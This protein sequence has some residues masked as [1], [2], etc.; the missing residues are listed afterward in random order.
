MRIDGSCHCGAIAYTAEVDPETVEIC[1]CTDCQALS[2]SAFRTVVPV[3]EDDFTLTAGEP[4]VYIKT[5]DSGAQRVQTFCSNCG[6]PIYSTSVGEGPKVFGIRV[7]TARQRDDLVP[8]SQF[9]A[10]S[11]QHWVAD[12]DTVRRVEKQ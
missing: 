2:G 9:W 5:A 6:S 1:H 11:A 4:K 8:K 10:R 7:G 3:A 12:L